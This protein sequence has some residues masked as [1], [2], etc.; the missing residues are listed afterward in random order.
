MKIDFREQSTL[1]S[2]LKPKK[3]RR[4]RQALFRVMLK[5]HSAGDLAAAQAASAGVIVLRSTVYDGLDALHIGLP[6]TVGASVRMAHLNTE[7]NILVTELT[8]C[9][10]EAPP[11]LCFLPY[12]GT[13]NNNSRT[14]GKLQGLFKLFLRRS[15]PCLGGA[16]VV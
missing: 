6:G 8:F 5:L 3:A 9:H 10:I 7:S 2:L 13:L 1:F 14:R 16:G 15:A 12:Q 4:V 11:C